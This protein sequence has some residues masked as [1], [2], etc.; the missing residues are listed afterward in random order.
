M[1]HDTAGHDPRLCR[2]RR[3]GGDRADRRPDR[4]VAEA[5]L[6]AGADMIDILVHDAMPG[7]LEPLGPR[8]AAA[9]RQMITKAGCHP[10]LPAALVRAAAA[11][12]RHARGGARRHGGA[13]RL[14]QPRGCGRGVQR[15]RPESP[16]AAGARP[17]ADGYVARHAPLRVRRRVRA[18]GGLSA[19]AAGDETARP[20]GAHRTRVV[21]RRVQ[22]VHRL[23]GRSRRAYIAAKIRPGLGR[24]LVCARCSVWGADRFEQ[25]VRQHGPAGCGWRGAGRRRTARRRAVVLELRSD[26]DGHGASTG[27]G[28]GP[29][30]LRQYAAGLTG[31][32]VGS[33]CRGWSSIPRRCSTTSQD[34]G[35]RIPPRG[36]R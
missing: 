16:G 24:R 6:A 22:L 5:A 18:D 34:D 20:A 2:G 17:L 7:R 10:G 31:G 15:A 27:A 1:R 30:L 4:A 21:R 3:G 11:E 14:R 35:R 9:G 13:R 12:S 32:A 36:Y 33:S 29:A 19:A 23:A 25:I 8:I 26:D 28:G